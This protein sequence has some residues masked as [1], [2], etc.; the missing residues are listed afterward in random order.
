[1]A[2]FLLVTGLNSYAER[3]HLAQKFKFHI[4][5]NVLVLALTILFVRPANSSN[6]YCS[7]LFKVETIRTSSNLSGKIG[8]Q[9][10][11]PSINRALE[12]ALYRSPVTRS[13]A[14]KLPIFGVEDNLVNL[15]ALSETIVEDLRTDPMDMSIMSTLPAEVL[16]VRN[17]LGIEYLN[18]KSRPGMGVS[19]ELAE[20]LLKIAHDDP[21]VGIEAL[22]I[23]D[24]D[25]ATGKHVHGFCFGRADY[26][27]F[28][29]LK[30]GVPKN[31]MYKLF[32]AGSIYGDPNFGRPWSN[33]V[34]LIVENLEGGFYAIDPLYNKVMTPD[35]WYETNNNVAK[36]H[37]S[38]LYVGMPQRTYTQGS[39]NT[40]QGLYDQSFPLIRSRVTTAT[41]PAENLFVPKNSFWKK[42]YDD[43]IKEILAK[44]DGP[45]SEYFCRVSRLCTK[46]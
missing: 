27:Y 19:R 43:M 9:I 25:P 44:N 7:S 37:R 46:D 36:L 4:V 12:T 40:R 1:M 35:E 17:R 41:G 14:H 10:S 34:V 26:L 39:I 11:F 29:F 31:S 42:Y 18:S 23:Y 45:F 13:F 22:K 6:E 3:V 30:R 21:V 5:V 24:I 8:R 28:E 2:H 20:E 33:H 16:E 38:F 15:L 32:Q